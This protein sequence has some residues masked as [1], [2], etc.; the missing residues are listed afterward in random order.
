V[1]LRGSSSTAVRAPNITELYA[2]RGQNFTGAANDPCDKAQ[3]VAIQNNPTQLATRVANCQATIP[4]YDPATFVS[5]IGVGRPSLQLLQGGNPDLKEETAD[6]F[7]AGVVVQPHWIEGLQLSADY[8]RINVQGAVSTIPINTLLQNLCYDVSQTPS[9]NHFCNLIHRDPTG[10]ITY[11]ELTNQN[12]QAIRT[13]GIDMSIS[14]QHGLGS[15]GHFGVQLDGTQINRWDLVGVPG[16]P[17]T[18]YAGILTGPNSDTPKYKVTGS[19]NWSWHDLSLTWVTHWL[20]SVGVSETLPPASE[21][22]FYTGS[23]YEHDFV[24]TYQVTSK[25]TVRAGAI[26]VTNVIPPQLPETAAGIGGGSS[27]Y[28]NRGRWFYVG[29]NYSQNQ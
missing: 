10:A 8:W 4:G 3:I 26:N 1:R 9:A 15:L 11:V 6:T 20:S 23:Y 25:L 5:N 27:A 16:G 17:V 22:P 13:N 18:R 14:Y 7:T 19:A 12:V 2:P 28:D 29:V 24:A 21:V